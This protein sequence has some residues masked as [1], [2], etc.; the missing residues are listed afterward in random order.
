MLEVND[1]HPF[2]VENQMEV[3]VKKVNLFS[4]CLF[5]ADFAH[6]RGACL[7]GPFLLCRGLCLKS[8]SSSMSTQKLST[9]TEVK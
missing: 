8:P 1:G 2:F 9:A 3:S 6:L 5:C 4:P 7:C